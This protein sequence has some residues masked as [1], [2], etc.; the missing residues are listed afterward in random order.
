MMLMAEKMAAFARMNESISNS[1]SPFGILLPVICPSSKYFLSVFGFNP[2]RL[3]AS[4]S[5]T[6]IWLTIADGQL[7]PTAW[8]L[9]EAR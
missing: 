2:V 4:R 8:S 9:S 7:H 1:L 5:G 3:T 6:S